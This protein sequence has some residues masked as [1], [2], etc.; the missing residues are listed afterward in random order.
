MDVSSSIKLA[1]CAKLLRGA[2]TFAFDRKQPTAQRSGAGCFLCWS[3]VSSRRTFA[4]EL[5]KYTTCTQPAV[6]GP[7]ILSW[8]IHISGTRSCHLVNTVMTVREP[9]NGPDTNLSLQTETTKTKRLS[10]HC[11]I[12]RVL[13]AQAKDLWKTWE[14][15]WAAPPFLAGA[16]SH[17]HP[18][19]PTLPVTA[20]PPAHHACPSASCDTWSQGQLRRIFLLCVFFNVVRAGLMWQ[21]VTCHQGQFRWLQLC[22]CSV[23]LRS[24]ACGCFFEE[25]FLP[26]EMDGKRDRERLWTT[27]QFYFCWGANCV[28]E[29]CVKVALFS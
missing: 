5:Y 20:A 8:A 26:C 12:P 19:P 21:P 27:T 17:A 25:Y 15:A 7:F 14:K 13:T 23:A 2:V 10:L 22:W 11:K 1:W 3:T 24:L 4:I 28:W 6:R 9:G 16:V 18:P 29:P